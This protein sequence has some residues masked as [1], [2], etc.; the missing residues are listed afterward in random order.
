VKSVRPF[1][2]L[3]Q[4]LQFYILFNHMW[5]RLMSLNPKAEIEHSHTRI[6]NESLQIHYED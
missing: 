5:P 1:Q 6:L 3:H 2:I 4:C